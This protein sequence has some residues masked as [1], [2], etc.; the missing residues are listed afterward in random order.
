MPDQSTDDDI[1]DEDISTITASLQ[2][3]PSSPLQPRYQLVP[4]RT[5]LETTASTATIAVYVTRVPAQLA[6]RV[7]E[8]VSPVQ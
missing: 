1:V 6:S 4:L 5:T 3:R 2:S 7:L 8:Y